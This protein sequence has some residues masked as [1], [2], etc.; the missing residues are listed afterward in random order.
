METNISFYVHQLHFFFWLYQYINIIW[1]PWNTFFTALESDSLQNGRKSQK[2]LHEGLFQSIAGLLLIVNIS[3]FMGTKTCF[4]AHQFLFFFWFFLYKNI[5]WG[6]WN[7]FHA[8]SRL[9]HSRKVNNNSYAKKNRD[10]FSHN[11]N[12]CIAALYVR[13]YKTMVLTKNVTYLDY[14]PLATCQGNQHESSCELYLG[15]AQG[16]CE[17]IG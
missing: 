7:T 1:G 8:A 4:Y 3:Y 17:G 6:P 11:W 13:P 10:S 14:H 12:A 5:K 2:S 16:T 15:V 9:L